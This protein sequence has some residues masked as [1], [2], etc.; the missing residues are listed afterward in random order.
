MESASALAPESK[1]LSS[2]DVM[3]NVEGVKESVQMSR[4]NKNV[5]YSHDTIKNSNKSHKVATKSQLQIISYPPIHNCLL[6]VKAGPGSGKTFTLTSRVAHLI[7]NYDM[8]PN[9]ILV[10]SMANRSVASLRNSLI[11]E[12]G[13]EVTSQIDLS[14]FHLFCGRLVDNYQNIYFPHLKGK[15]LMDD[16][17]WRLFS[18]IF[19]NKFINL[20]GK[21]I[22]GSLSPTNLEK[23]VSLVRNDKL[24]SEQAAEKFKINKEYV[25]SLLK[26]LDDNGVIRY[27]DLINNAKKIIDMSLSI[28]NSYPESGFPDST[29][30][31]PYIDQLYNYKVV[32]VDEFQDMYE[33]LLTVVNYVAKYPTVGQPTNT[34]KHIT[35]AGDPNQSIYEF[36]GSKSEIMEDVEKQFPPSL[37][38]E[39]KIINESFRCS[40]EIL[41]GAIKTCLGEEGLSKNFYSVK[42]ST[43]LPVLSEFKD[44]TEEYNFI[45]NE[46]IRICCLLGGLIKLSDIA[47]LARSNREI[48]D[49]NRILADNYGIGFNKLSSSLSW[50]KSKAHILLTILTAIESSSNNELLLLY[51]LLSI[52]E[53]LGKKSRI[54]KLF[55]LSRKW[56]LAENV[57]GDV[58]EQYLISNFHGNLMQNKDF[59]IKKIFKKTHGV[60]IEKFQILMDNIMEIRIALSRNYSN[61]TPELILENLLTISDKLGL[62]DYLN[63]PPSPSRLMT[64]SELRMQDLTY[65]KELLNQLKSFHRSLL[66]N[67]QTYLDQDVLHNSGDNF[68]KFFLK[69]YNEDYPIMSGELVNTSTIHAAKGLEFPI[70]FIPGS[71]NYS[72]GPWCSI[73]TRQQEIPYSGSRLLYVAS[74]RAKNLLYLGSKSSIGEVDEQVLDKF[75]TR[76]PQFHNELMRQLSNDLNRPLP[77]KAKLHEGA[78]LLNSFSQLRQQRFFH[79][80][81]ARYNNN[82]INI[83]SNLL[84]LCKR[85]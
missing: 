81:A 31:P 12:L 3:Y 14:T 51:L 7:K 75:T 59:S 42:E 20:D 35:I 56:G 53:D 17:S 21:S 38:I 15:R 47:I 13:E 82:V 22:Q 18:S 61:Q 4:A 69:N 10:L 48:E 65:K 77:S 28:Q 49:I 71:S 41:D 9:E 73:L 23:L 34:C 27:N 55:S 25:D 54:S 80:F 68:L 1:R 8:K 78:K 67:Y 58:L 46:I 44:P 74:T 50:T 76:P 62:L 5:Q 6:S 60:K 43:H 26:Y 2:G 64:L 70:V 45:I 85:R 39:H 16:L 63:E 84:N 83:S 19:L 11:E 72:K 40:P 52:D 36:L 29:S 57:K 33:D 30:T 79:T 66:M 32:I 24:T 37:K